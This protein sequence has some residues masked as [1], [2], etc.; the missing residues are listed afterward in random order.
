MDRES[1][2][3]TVAAAVTAS[4]LPAPPPVPPELPAMEPAGLIPLFRERAALVDSVV[5]GPVAGHGV[6]QLVT[7]IASAHGCVSFVAWD[8]L[9][10][11][12]IPA[13][14][15]ANGLTHVDHEIAPVEGRRE[16]MVAYGAVSMGITGS[17]AGLAESG[18]V[19]LDH[20]EGQPRLASLVPETHVVLLEIS[21]IARSLAHWAARHPDLATR[22]ANLVVV[23]GPSR[24][25]DIEQILNL[26]VHGPR[27]LHVVL[28]Q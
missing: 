2:L 27:N 4:Q 20:S 26:G 5:H 13:A 22:S 3:S 24:T 23:T 14:L 11:P 8:H 21:T 7:A 10:I 1:F 16:Q 9:P 12:G 6:P 25:G 17:I 28:I 19:V 18:S 15:S